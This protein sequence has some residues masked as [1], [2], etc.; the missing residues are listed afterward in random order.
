MSANVHRESF[1]LTVPTYGLKR[2]GTRAYQVVT[3]SRQVQ[4]SVEVDMEGIALDIGPRAAR[5]KRRRATGLGG[6]VVLRASK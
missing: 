1:T 2:D 3:G 6:R 5:S 4:V